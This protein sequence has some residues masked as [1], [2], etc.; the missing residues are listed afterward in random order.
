MNKI[1]SNSNKKRGQ[2]D[3]TVMEEYK[4]NW[5]KMTLADVIFELRQN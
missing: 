3:K 5:S 1:T 2:V 4:M